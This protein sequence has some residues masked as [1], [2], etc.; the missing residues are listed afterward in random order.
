[1]LSY[2][3]NDEF[4]D[5]G[6]ELGDFSE[7]YLPTHFAVWNRK[8]TRPASKPPAAHHSAVGCYFAHI[9]QKKQK[10][11]NLRYRSHKIG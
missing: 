1:M 10:V 9:G 4:Q 11:H 7:E 8:E 2:V 3:F 5:N 6:M